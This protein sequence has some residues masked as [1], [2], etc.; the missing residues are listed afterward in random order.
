MC[1]IGRAD[2]QFSVCSLGHFSA[3]SQKEQLKAVEKVFGYLKDF[4]DMRIKI[5]HW[6]LKVFPVMST[7]DASFKEPYPDA[8]EEL[9]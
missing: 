2:I 4:P 5:D 6:D 7:P 8:F 1:S 3:C 9:D